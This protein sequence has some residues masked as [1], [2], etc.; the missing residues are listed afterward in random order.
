MK[1]IMMALIFLLNLICLKAQDFTNETKQETDLR[2]EWWNDAKFGMFIHWGVYSVPAGWYKDKMIPGISEWIMYSAKIPVEEYEKYAAV[3]NPIEYDPIKWVKI[4]KQA[5]MKYIVITS[6]HHDG[7]SIWDS[8]VTNYDIV[9]YTP[10]KKDILK[11]L[12]EAC[13]NEGIK[14][15]FYHSIMDWHHPDATKENFAKY[16]DEYLIPQ[17]EELLN[18]FDNLSILWFDGEWIEEWTEPQG[19]KL[20]NHLRNKKPELIINNRIGKGRQGMQG[21]NKDH[22]FVGD[23]GTPEQEILETSSTL[24][25]ESCMTMNDSW[26]FKRGDE[27]WKSSETIIYNIIDIAS[28]GG[29][30]LLN[31]GPD[32]KGNIPHESIIRLEQVGNWMKLNSEGIYNTRPMKNYFEGENIKYTKSKNSDYI[33]AYI[34]KKPVSDSIKIKY[35]VPKDNSKIFLLSQNLTLNYSIKNNETIVLL[36]SGIEENEYPICLKIEGS[37]K[38]VA[39]SPIVKVNEKVVKDTY[40]FQDSIDVEI[41]SND[42]GAEIK[43]TTDGTLPNQNSKLYS[44]KLK[45]NKSASLKSISYKNDFVESILKTVQFYKI[46]SVKDLQIKNNPSEKYSNLNKFILVDGK[47]G[48]EEYEDN[49]WLG[50]EGVNFETTIDLGQNKKVNGI[51]IGC[52]SDLNSWIFLPKKVTVYISDNNSDFNKISEVKYETKNTE[53]QKPFVKDFSAKIN[54]STRFIK[55]I[56]ENIKECP[57]WH[58]GSGGKAWLFVDEIIL[59]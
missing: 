3:F 33:Y 30:Y 28:K 27:N 20:Y 7:F 41:I 59:D 58:K 2:M 19:K 46:K 34:L 54:S 49:N 44:S 47:R 11:P 52:L 5:G 40:L 22:S 26:G 48:S 56:A 29:N 4:A 15:G 23:F 38:K 16:R 14:L 24:P 55:I 51:H 1:N 32:E 13:K 21:M 8:K 57:S 31:V 39:S 53:T 35:V 12:A 43:Y 10:Y 42:I 6:K 50:F 18:E 17:L 37:E 9:D 36:P 45:I 25:W